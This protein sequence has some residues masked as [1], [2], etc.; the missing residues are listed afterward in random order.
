MQRVQRDAGQTS[1]EYLGMVVV[2]ALLVGA[3][4]ASGLAAGLADSLR[5]AICEI[6][7]TSCPVDVGQSFEPESCVVASSERRVDASVKVTFVKVGGSEGYVREERSNGEI[8]VTWVTDGSAGLTAGAG[9]QG[10]IR[11]DGDGVRGG[12]SASVDVE[13][14][15]VASQTWV[16]TDPA[17]A[18]RY[19]RGQRDEAIRRHTG[20]IGSIDRFVRGSEDMRTPD[21]VAFD[22]TAGGGAGAGAGFGPADAEVGVDASAVIGGTRDMRTGETTLYIKADGSISGEAGVLLGVSGSEGGGAVV[23][24]TLDA[25][26][27][28]KTLTVT[29]TRESG[30]GGLLEGSGYTLDDLGRDLGEA[31][32]SV[33]G[34]DTRTVVVTSELDL[35]DAANRRA[36]MDF[37]TAAGG[38][39]LPGGA[40]RLA[41]AAAG[42]QG[43]LLDNGTISAT[44]HEGQTTGLG[45]AA[46]VAL[47]PKLGFDVGY[48]SRDAALTGAAFLDRG[49]GGGR[50][51][52][53]WTSCTG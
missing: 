18:D 30:R 43:R 17:E 29:S 15:A 16:F 39:A 12:G 11:I 23:A 21:I 38:A 49:P 24:L 28:P 31:S 9:V 8:H 22:V 35:R 53:P 26:N 37:V 48:D 42:L 40:Q 45:A 10:G 51:F 3:L 32:I 52:V 7:G 5:A 47:G 27:Q 50:V 1:A 19:I 41:D 44:E 13:I 4:A 2:V 6:T 20:P 33:G 46:E 25:D 36:A 34:E 14:G